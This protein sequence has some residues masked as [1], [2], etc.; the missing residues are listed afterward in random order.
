M[1]TQIRKM[2]F[3]IFKKIIPVIYLEE[4]LIRQKT[5]LC[6]QNSTIGEN[7]YFLAGAKVSNLQNNSQ[8]IVIDENTSIRGELLIFAYGG[9]IQIGKYCYVG[10]HSRIWSGE[11]IVIGNHVLIAHNVNIV[12]TNSHE[13]PHIE[14]A[15]RYKDLI[16]KGYP[17]TKASIK[18]SPIIIEDYAWI[19]FNAIILKGVR[20]G[21]GAIVA[22]GAVVTKDVP[23]FTLVAGNPAVVVKQ[24]NP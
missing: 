16:T 14:R 20:I 9:E 11:K 17:K 2:I 22:A 8:K 1:I 18:T 4:E 10:D 15:E 13:I 12:D 23:P 6:L 19:S 7:S 3:K 5:L 21:K 24:I